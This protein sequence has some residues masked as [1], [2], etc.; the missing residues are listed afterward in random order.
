MVNL[1]REKTLLARAVAGESGINF[2]YLSASEFEQSLVGMGTVKLK[3][4]FKYARK[5][6]PCIIFIDEIDSLLH[7]CKR[8]G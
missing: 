2:I 1:E 6:Q 3:K 7:K 5:N 4:L 8:S